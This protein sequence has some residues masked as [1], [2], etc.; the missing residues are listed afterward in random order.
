MMIKT[1]PKGSDDMAAASSAAREAAQSLLNSLVLPCPFS[2]RALLQ[3]AQEHR[4]RP[5]VLHPV[6]P[7]WGGSTGWCGAWLE[8]P[9]TDHIAFVRDPSTVKTALTVIHE[10]GHVFFDHPGEMLPVTLAL[11]GID[12]ATVIRARGRAAFGTPEEQEAEAFSTLVLRA[13][14]FSNDTDLRIEASP[15]AALLKAR[16]E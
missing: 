15:E 3:Q 11:G 4:Q 13:T 2:V 10:L 14:M 5:I 12:T 16:F 7:E 1:K 6:S 9:T 8:T